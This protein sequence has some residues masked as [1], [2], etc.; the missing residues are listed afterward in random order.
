MVAASRCGAGPCEP[1]IR[2]V[3]LRHAAALSAAALILLCLS[4]CSLI[5]FKSLDRPLSARDM[6]ARILTRE[7]ATQFG[8]AVEERA[9]DIMAGAAQPDVVENAL[10]WKIAAV[11]ASQRAALQMAPV[12]SL[13]DSW[14]LAAQMKSFMAAGNAG[15][16]LFGAQQPAAVAVASRLAD[17]AERLARGLMS[18]EEFE[19]Y[20]AFV[21]TYARDNPLVDL[22]FARASVVGSWS[23]EKGTDA[24]LVDSLGTIPEATADMAQRLQMYGDTA[25]SQ[26]MW[27]T[28]LTLLQAGYTGNDIH[29]ALVQLDGRLASLSTVANTAPELMHEGVA[30]V[31]RSLLE[32]IDRL[33]FTV[34]ATIE[35]LRAERM[36]VTESVHTERE[37]MTDTV[38]VQRKAI[39]LDAANITDQ[40]VKSSGEQLRRLARE[41]LV[42]IIV[43]AAVILGLPFAAGYMVGRTRL[44]RARA[45]RVSDTSSRSGGLQ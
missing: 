45:A 20:R 41:A 15:G 19:Q 14:A 4:G 29:S 25:P 24:K 1:E 40:V 39:A 6:N 35:A 37:A 28:Q 33:N 5:S 32:A 30:D 34:A 9:N 2:H 10:R 13:L 16:A 44:E 12:M 36:A 43:L 7:Y 27:Q 11:G 17:D 42:L 18:P 21:V 23:R 31:R 3:V 22:T 26:A 38:D 8:A